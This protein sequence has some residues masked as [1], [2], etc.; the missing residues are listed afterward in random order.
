MHPAWLNFI[1]EKRRDNLLRILEEL[2]G[3]Q[4]KNHLNFII[5][6]AL[7]LLFA[8]YLKY[9]RYW[10]IDILF[11][12]HMHL[13]EFIEK[14]K[15]N[16]LRIVDYDEALMVSKNISSFH[17]AWTFGHVWF[18][19]DYILRQGF[20][21]YHTHSIAQLKRFKDTINF[22]GGSHEIDLYIAHTWGIIV[23][24]IFSPRLARD[25]ESKIDT[26]VDLTHIIKVY[27]QEKD[28]M[29]F[30][31]YTFEKA[32]LLQSKEAFKKAF[33][34]I[35]DALDELGYGDIQ[36]SAKSLEILRAA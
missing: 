7:P 30:W 3:L 32:Q 22:N 25:M 13:T 8:G 11:K 31:K 26:S 21:E 4:D 35:L 29:D 24:K 9:K 17:T 15:S 16:N 18:N 12:D 10:D 34:K 5:V 36:V 33:L 1:D 23:E 2:S 20:F 27:N 19:V 14:P 6:G 28:N